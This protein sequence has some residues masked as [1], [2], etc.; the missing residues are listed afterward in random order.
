MAKKSSQTDNRNEER[1][2]ERKKRTQPAPV[3][4]SGGNPEALKRGSQ[5]G[6]TR[7]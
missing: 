4:S 1:S 7:R 5:K 2:A 6:K 3:P